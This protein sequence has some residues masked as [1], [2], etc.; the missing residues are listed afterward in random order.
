MP[1][2]G[3]NVLTG[4]TLRDDFAGQGLCRLT[5]QDE[6]N[7]ILLDSESQAT[8]RRGVQGGVGSG[9][10]STYQ[11]LSTGLLWKRRIG[12]LNFS[13]GAPDPAFLASLN[14]LWAS[15]PEGSGAAWRVGEQLAQRW[16]QCR[17]I[18]PPFRIPPRLGAS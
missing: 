12:Y 17:R 2:A 15:A 10:R 1:W 9:W 14:R 4:K 3:F 5:L 8:G 7:R 13:S 16:G 18:L 11:V 6:R